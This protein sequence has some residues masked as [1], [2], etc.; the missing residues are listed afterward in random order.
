MNV[1]KMLDV[2]RPAFKLRRV[3]ADWPSNTERV[4]PLTGAKDLETATG[5]LRDSDGNVRSRG[6]QLC[7]RTRQQS[8]H[9]I[10][11]AFERRW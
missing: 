8:S 10:R 5:I 4:Q 1:S 11:Y 7:L 3:G 2:E 6:N 9:S